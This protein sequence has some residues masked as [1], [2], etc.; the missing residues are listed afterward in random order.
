MD[1]NKLLTGIYAYIHDIFVC[2]G[3]SFACP[4]TIFFIK[5][6]AQDLPLHC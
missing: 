3:R 2:R 1:G 4:I 5:G 6:Q